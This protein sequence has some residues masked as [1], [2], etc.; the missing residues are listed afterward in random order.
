VIR[1]SPCPAAGVVVDAAGARMGGAARYLDELRGYL[2]RSPR[3]DVTVI[4]V[5]RGLR[6]TWLLRREASGG[7]RGARR[8]V[9]LN[10]IGFC[11]PGGERWTLLRNALHFLSAC[12]E[13]ELDR[14]LLAR[15]R[16]QAA[17]V[18]LAARRSDV[19]VVPS[20]AMAGRVIQAMPGVSDR[21]VIRPHPV[22]AGPPRATGAEPAIVC[23][24]LFAPYKHM[25]Q[26]LCELL[27]ALDAHDDPRVRVWVT[28]EDGEVPAGLAAH[29]RVDLLGRRRGE[30]S[31][32]LVGRAR[33]VYFPGGL[34]SFGYP[35]A[36]ARV[37]GRPVI[38]GDTTQNR[39]IAGQALC[40]YTPG[41][42]GSLELAVKT[43]LT[44]RVSPDPGPFDPGAY[45]DWLLGHA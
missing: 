43:A 2:E 35:L 39:E 25:P 7:A 20:T 31:S 18:R 19:L 6:P 21:V 11:G 24:V 28:A 10:N 3:D 15:T 12:E 29:P 5:G 30:E 23:P 27:T 22:S 13:A 42:P 36:E 14:E 37:A 17:I 34:E 4:G 40:G 16:R 38:A 9:A 33:A 32:V 41:D 26:R 8:R 44:V 45:F 1:Q